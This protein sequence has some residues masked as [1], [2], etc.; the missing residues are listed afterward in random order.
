M[1]TLV[2]GINPIIIKD[3]NITILVKNSRKKI[4]KLQKDIKEAYKK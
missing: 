3:K 1:T 4:E 2:T